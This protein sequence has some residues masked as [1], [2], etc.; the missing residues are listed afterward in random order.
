VHGRL[1]ILKVKLVSVQAA[2]L[3]TP[4]TEANNIL[5]AT[6]MRMFV[7]QV[8]LKFSHSA[9]GLFRVLAGG[10]KLIFSSPAD[11]AALSLLALLACLALNVG[12]SLVF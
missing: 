9:L 1:T 12:S 11:D 5:N 3:E 7:I 8:P 4:G 10:A 6:T 2:S